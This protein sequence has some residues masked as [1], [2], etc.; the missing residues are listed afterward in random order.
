MQSAD[1]H[2]NLL[3]SHEKARKGS[4][5]D[6]VFFQH[7]IKRRNAQAPEPN[8]APVLVENQAEAQG[9][10]LTFTAEATGDYYVYVTNRKVKEV[11][12]VV[13]ER[14]LSFDN[15]DRGYFLELGWLLEGQEVLVESETEGNPAMQ[16]QVWRFDP[17]ALKAVSE[18]LGKNPI[19]LTSWTDTG[20]AGSITSDKPGVMFTSIPYDKGW[21]VLGDGEKAETR[22]VFDTFLAVDLTEGTHKIS[23]AYEPPGLRTGAWITSVS[24]AVL[25]LL[26]AGGCLLDRYNEKNKNKTE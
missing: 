6:S 3:S 23:L 14:S 15:V 17:E 20:L 22:A 11:S 19:T 2:C 10:K 12:V 24:L 8:T 13:G 18:K 7:S 26:A 16:A 9:K 4:G 25:A 5:P 21:S 1:P